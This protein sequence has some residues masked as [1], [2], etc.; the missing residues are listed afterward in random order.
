MAYNFITDNPHQFLTGDK[1]TIYGQV[2]G[3][4]RTLE[5]VTVTLTLTR[6][7]EQRE[8]AADTDD[9]GNFTL[10]LN[11]F[12]Q[13]DSGSVIVKALESDN[14]SAQLDGSIND[15]VTSLTLKSITGTVPTSGWLKINNEWMAFT[16]T[17]TSATVTRAQF[18]TTA[19][20]HTDSDS[21]RFADSITSL[22][23]YYDWKVYDIALLPTGVP[24]E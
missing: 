8:R 23:P 14:G 19:A 2:S 17:G 4:K 11:E 21:I 3:N 5:A 9:S 7:I 22:I 12:S 10:I 20:S 1:P 24:G 18:G 15:T 13:P 16:R 6:Q